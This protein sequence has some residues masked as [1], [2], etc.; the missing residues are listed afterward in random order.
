MNNKIIISIWADPTNYINLLFL[1]NY[2]IKKKQKITLICRN[3]ERKED[4]F[5]FIKK[6]NNLK[7]VELNQNGKLGYFNFLILKI[8]F[9]LKIKPKTVISINFISLFVSRFVYNKK[10]NWIYYNFD[11]DI[12]KKLYLNNY[13]E[14]KIIQ[15]VSCI[16]LPSK[17]RVSLYKKIFLR[18]NKIYPI[19]NCFSKNFKI[20]NYELKKINSKLKNKNYIVRLGSFYKHHYL[21]E[22]A[23]KSKSWKNNLYLVLAGKSYAGY[24]NEMQKFKKK[25]NLSKLILLKDISYKKWF[26]LLENA[27]AGIALY[28]SINVSHNLMGGTSQKLNNYIFASIPSFINNNNDF[29]KFNKKYKTSIIVNNSLHDLNRK[30]HYLFK[31]KKFYRQ[32]VKW[33]K[34]AFKNEFNFE[35]QIE[36]VKDHILIKNYEGS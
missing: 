29:I 17:S 36:K 20:R 27:L 5:Y 12:S 26:V 4:F 16:F 31:N 8:F 33:N 25:H 9:F 28:K 3:I 34:S 14:K 15:K 30:I 11:F 22:V 35:N 6:S 32:K 1:I 18:K 2:L 7:V 23:I 21:K 10:V 19:Y 24:F 13:I